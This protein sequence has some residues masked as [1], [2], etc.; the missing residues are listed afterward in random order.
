MKRVLSVTLCAVLIL[1]LALCLGAC[2][3]SDITGRYNL[4]SME[5]EGITFDMEKLKQMAGEDAEAYIEL[6]ADGTA[7]MSMMGEVAELKYADGQMWPVE[8]EDDK[9]PFTIKGNTLTLEQDGLKVIF[10]K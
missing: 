9:A 3:K 6:R 4:K 5:A 7:T 8:D 2:G 10:E 1:S